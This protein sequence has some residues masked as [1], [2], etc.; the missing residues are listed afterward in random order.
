MLVIKAI[1][2]PVVIRVNILDVGEI[3]YYLLT[4]IIAHIN[5]F[6]NIYKSKVKFIGQLH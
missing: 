2:Y 1:V 6:R 5:D 3:K 4:I